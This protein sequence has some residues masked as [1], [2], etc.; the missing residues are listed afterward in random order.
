MF[1]PDTVYHVDTAKVE[2]AA[3]CSTSHHLD[4][5]WDEISGIA[6]SKG[7]SPSVQLHLTSLLS[8]STMSTTVLSL[9]FNKNETSIVP[10]WK[11][12]LANIKSDFST[13]YKLQGNVLER[14]W[15]MAASPMS[16]L[17]A[18][19]TVLLPSDS[20]AYMTPSDYRTVVNITRQ[21]AQDDVMPVNCGF[22]RPSDLK[23][24]V[25]LFAAKSYVK[26]LS[27]PVDMDKLVRAMSSAFEVPDDEI[28]YDLNILMEQGMEPL[29]HARYL[30]LR[31]F[32]LPEMR[33]ARFR[34]LAEMASKRDVG[35]NSISKLVVEHLVAEVLKIPASFSRAGKLSGSI[36]KAYETLRLKLQPEPEFSASENATEIFEETCRI[37]SETIPFESIKWARCKNGHQFSRCGLTFLAMQEP[38]ISKQCTMCG[39]QFL[40][41]WTLPTL[42]RSS[43]DQDVDM[44][45]APGENEPR[46]EET[47]D[48]G[49]GNTGIV[50][51]GNWVHVVKKA[52]QA[53]PDG[54]LARILFAAF[55][56]CVYCGGNF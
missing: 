19:A 25:L 13:Q 21:N 26:Q 24:A 34:L 3:G 29:Q 42:V 33:N 1:G 6:F 11:T 53:E 39:T 27:G 37:C 49:N 46:G 36:Y 51:G 30:R 28:E 9:P 54:S 48:R 16:D 41:E 50:T 56:K 14:V 23:S 12:A 15:G 20:P 31:L 52:A 38:G 43:E 10:A 44:A 4:G 7:K 40:N 35:I 32:I 2:Q 5:R 55:D 22:A 18:T 8:S 47:A 45:D 17:I